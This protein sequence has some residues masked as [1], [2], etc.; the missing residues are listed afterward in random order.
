MLGVDLN[1]FT[2]GKDIYYPFSVEMHYFRVDKRY[3]SV[4]FE[5]IKRAGF[6]IIST[7]IPW[8]LHQ[9]RNKD[10]DFNGFQD[11]RKDLVVF[12]ELAREFGFKVILRPGPWIAG[13][14]KNGGIPDF[15]LKDSELLARDAEGMPIEIE[16]LSGVPGGKLISYLHPHFQHFL[17]NYMK[18]LIETTRN[19][20]HP[21]G[22]V[23]MV[24]FDF[25]TSFCHK[26]GPGEADYNDY[27]VKT[28]Y[29]T[30]LEKKYGEIKALN[31]AYKERHKHF[32][33]VEPPREF[34]D[35]DLKHLPKLFDWFYFKE[36]YLS[37]YLTGL[38]EL[39]KS[40]TVMPLFFR[41][42]Y[43]QNEHPLPVFSLRTEGEE[44]QEHLIGASV[45]P[46][47]T[48][49][50]LMQKAR[51]MRTMTD[52]AW[53]PSFISGNF[54]ANQSESEAMF[55]I[56]DGRRRFFV[57][58]GLAGGFKGIN[59]YMFINRDHW[60]GAP[61]DH[62]GTIKSGF[63]IIKR[64]NIA[65]PKMEANQL[66]SNTSLAAAFYRPYQWMTR[67]PKQ[68]KFAYIKRLLR[69]TFNGLCRDFSRLGFDFGVGDI[70]SPEKLEKFKT[71]FIPVGEVM[72][73]EAQ[74]NIVGLAE[75]G[76]NVILSGLL[77]KY[78]NNGRENSTL[79]KKL[80]IRTTPG[81][82]IVEVD[83]G[84]SGRFTTYQYG[85]VRTTDAKVK[86]VATA[87]GKPVGVVS[88]RFK[89][90]VFVFSYDLASG[91]DYRKLTYLEQV[92]SEAKL[93]TPVY[94]SD[95]NI[96]V[97]LLKGE[98][99][100]VIFVLAPPAGELGDATDLRFKQIL[101]KVDLRKAGFKGTKI[102]LVDQFADEE[103]PPI[104][105]T[106]DEL[107]NGI[108][109]DIGFPDGKIFTVEK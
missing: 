84:R 4:C 88:T 21:R 31:V 70:D 87:K 46:D 103:D 33:D 18:N 69:E 23:F 43:F 2:I 61:V 34:T 80:R 74:N 29:P 5:R 14:W 55:P 49:F 82:G 93:S 62:D 27:V 107:K 57:A 53:A 22:P 108:A 26:T 39:F 92:L 68:Q 48:A 73:A 104:K 100:F 90:K 28:L 44:E 91:G 67:L 72:S 52:F 101:L 15:V 41:S 79:S 19:Y 3:W 35:T 98:K 102:K 63:G 10:I 81:D 56:S 38:E 99:A 6:R 105:T 40:Y 64:L 76:V 95:P 106:V 97:I 45:F 54:T 37:E 58:A 24:E 20:I 7:A 36:W 94:I 13:Q 77:P 47:G 12:L 83:C 50:D 65:I 89:G 71:V 30:F 9:D 60:Y 11:S 25:E 1:R 86:K 51:Y 17:K 78:D 42:L 75:K 96:E 66:E 8:N 85:T 109:F 59:H 32:A 16:D